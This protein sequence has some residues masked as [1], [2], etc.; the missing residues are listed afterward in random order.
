MIYNITSPKWQLDDASAAQFVTQTRINSFGH[1]EEVWDLPLGLVLFVEYQ[2]TTD[3]GR[4][5]GCTSG[6][7]LGGYIGVS[8]LPPDEFGEPGNYHIGTPAGV[9]SKRLIA[10]MGA[11]M[12]EEQTASPVSQEQVAQL[13]EKRDYF[14]A[15][16]KREEERRA[17]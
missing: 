14:F 12:T 15:N 5:F 13:F 9:C 8:Y 6:E 4:W 3:S 10:A 2:G 7:K 11:A 1:Y 17:Q 16:L